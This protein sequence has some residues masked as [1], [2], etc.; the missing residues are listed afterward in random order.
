MKKTILRTF[1]LIGLS[2]GF[3]LT[4][5]AVPLEI[6]HHEDSQPGNSGESTINSWIG[7]TVTNYNT[8]HDPDLPAPGTQVFRVNSEGE[9][10][11]TPPPAY[12]SYPTFGDVSSILLPVGDF[13]Y[14]ALHWGGPGGGQ[15]QIFYIGD[16]EGSYTFTSPDGAK[17]LSWYSFFG[18]RNGVPDSGS[19]LILLGVALLGLMGFRRR[20]A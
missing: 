10:D 2:L 3:A 13:T 7:T 16:S 6:T 15:Y 9:A 17:G 1:A 19:T 20:L 11:A 4:A 8:A 14:V 12:S 5:S 18:S